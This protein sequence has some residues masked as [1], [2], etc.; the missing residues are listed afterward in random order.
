[1]V[2]A[3]KA[4]E[5]FFIETGRFPSDLRAHNVTSTGYSSKPNPSLGRIAEN[6]CREFVKR[7]CTRGSACKFYHP[8]P[9]ELEVLLA[10]QGK[11]AEGGGAPNQ[12]AG[13]NQAAG[14]N[15]AAS[16]GNAAPQGGEQNT[17]LKSRVN[18]LERLLADACYCMTL[19]VGDQNPAI[20]TLMKTITDMAPESTLANQTAGDATATEEG[21][22]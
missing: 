2:H 5:D 20:S 14:T 21:N 3:R 22:S 15:Q 18:Q 7:Q 8:T 16:G 19:A 9:Q 4:D 11:P 13:S 10:Q 1:M 6:V 12:T 17:A